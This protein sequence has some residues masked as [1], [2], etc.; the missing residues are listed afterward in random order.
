MA[1]RTLHLLLFG[2]A[3]LSSSGDVVADEADVAAFFARRQAGEVACTPTLPYFCE[4]MHV[5]CAGRTTV[6]TFEFKL[7]TT[8]SAGPVQLLAASEEFQKIYENADVEWGKDGD[9]V[10]LSPKAAKGYV[11]LV[12]D[13]KYVFRHYLQSVGVMSLG[14]CR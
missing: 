13:G 7:R 14:H 3:W 8:A 12:S 9:Y 6:P 4:N 10:L 11:K 1:A 5:R 2:I